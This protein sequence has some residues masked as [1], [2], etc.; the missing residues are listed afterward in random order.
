M[1]KSVFISMICSLFIYFSLNAANNYFYERPIAVVD[2]EN[3][4]TWHLKEYG[5]RELSEEERKA[6]S[7]KFASSLDYAISDIQKNQRVT[8][9]VKPAVVTDVPDYTDT[10]KA[11]ITRD[12]GK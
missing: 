8:L 3:I 4:I 9:L 12:M 5:N 10:V 11:M 6:A 7:E 2:L 1:L